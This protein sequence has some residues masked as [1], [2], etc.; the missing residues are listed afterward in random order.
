MHTKQVK[1]F[2][3]KKINMKSLH[4]YCMHN[5]VQ[6]LFACIRAYSTYVSMLNHS[7]YLKMPHILVQYPGLKASNSS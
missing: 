2:K 7:L 6:L 5:Y 4:T 1:Y 3:S